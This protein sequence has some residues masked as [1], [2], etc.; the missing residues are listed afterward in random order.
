M[1]I[2][3]LPI[4]LFAAGWADMAVAA[5]E[6]THHEPASI[7]SLFL[8]VVNFTIFVVVF[9]WY[10]WPVIRGALVERRKAVEK[11]LSEGDRALADAQGALA[12]IEQRRAGLAAEGERIVREMREEAEHDRAALVA[13]AQKSAERIREDAK[14]LGEQEGDRAA[15]TIREEIAAKVVANVTAALRERV[16]GADEARLVDEFVATVEQ[17]AQ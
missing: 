12:T 2:R 17:P 16:S 15:R 14:L 6:A 3:P 8:P 13:A 1:K 9:A 5:E 11:E 4:V 7:T 10:A